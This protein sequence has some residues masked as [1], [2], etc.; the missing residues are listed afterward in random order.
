MLVLSVE[1]KGSTTCLQFALAANSNAVFSLLLFLL[2]VE[3][4]SN[5]FNG[6]TKIMYDELPNLFPSRSE[7]EI[8]DLYR[9][10]ASGLVSAYSTTTKDNQQ[11]NKDVVSTLASLFISDKIRFPCLFPSATRVDPNNPRRG[12]EGSIEPKEYQL[13]VEVMQ[14]RIE[15]AIQGTLAD[16]EFDFSE[17]E[18]AFREA[19]RDQNPN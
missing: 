12:Y 18:T 4:L 8:V 2:F 10:F 13:A 15:R 3:I 17:S 6:S 16:N 9:A 19:E 7:G 5:Y 14:R 11:T 1:S